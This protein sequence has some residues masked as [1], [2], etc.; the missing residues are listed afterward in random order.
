MTTNTLAIIILL[1][2]FLVMIALRFPIA[3]AVGISSILCFLYRGVPITTVCQQ[4]V[5]GINSFSL[6]AVPFF[7]TS[8]RSMS[9]GESNASGLLK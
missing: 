3:Y 4:M 9:S 2:S 1:G 8:M 7:I 5:K 6:M